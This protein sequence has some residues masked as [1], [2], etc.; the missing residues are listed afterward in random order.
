MIVDSSAIIAMVLGE[1]ETRTLARAL[2]NSQTA[3][4]SAPVWLEMSMVIQSPRIG[5]ARPYVERFV[6][7]LGLEV[8]AFSEQHAAT[9][10]EAWQRYGKGN[11]PARLNFGDC[12]SYA[13]AK[14]AGE[15]LLYVGDDFAQTDIESALG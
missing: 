6:R 7:G 9:A 3:R 2:A 10:L 8:V 11:H 14:L 4:I 1:P 15:P 13:T 5:Q 12:M